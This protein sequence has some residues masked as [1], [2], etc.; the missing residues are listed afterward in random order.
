VPGEAKALAH[1]IEFDGDETVPFYPAP[2]KCAESQAAVLG[3]AGLLASTIAKL[4]YGTE[5]DVKIDVYVI[6]C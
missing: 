6:S 2:Y 4:R 3:Y 1:T 5:Q